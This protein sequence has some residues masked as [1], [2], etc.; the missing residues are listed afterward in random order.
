LSIYEISMTIHETI[1]APAH[2]SLTIAVLVLPQS[3]ILEV[4]SVL[5]P[6]RAANRHLGQDA[7]RW[8]VVSP[9]GRPVPL[10]CGIELPSSGALAAAEGADALILIVGYRQSEVAT[11]PLLRDLARMAPRFRLIAGVDAGSWVMARAGLLDGHR[12]TVHWEDLED[13]AAAHP[14]VDVLPDRWVLDRMRAT[15][16]PRLPCAPV[17]PPAAPR[18]SAAPLPRRPPASGPGTEILRSRRVAAGPLPP[19]ASSDPPADRICRSSR[20]ATSGW[21]GSPASSKAAKASAS[22]T[23]DHM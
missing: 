11:R 2:R 8:R 15:A 4:A 22:I 21:N 18:L 5:D 20:A 1:F 19:S 14:Q 10:T 3:S 12:A 17:S 6:M 9:D 13:F 7:Y 23:S 16:S